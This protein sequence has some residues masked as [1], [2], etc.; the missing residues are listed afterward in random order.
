MK[1]SFKYSFL[2]L[3]ILPLF[4]CGKIESELVFPENLHTINL[5]NGNIDY[6]TPI[7]VIFYLDRGLTGYYP[8]K[9]IFKWDETFKEKNPDVQL[10]IYLGNVN[11]EEN[12]QETLDE[13]NFNYPVILDPENLFYESNKL[14][15]IPWGTTRIIGLLVRDKK[16]ID[17][18]QVGM[19]ELLQEQIAKEKQRMVR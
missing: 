12:I 2:F 3:L 14:D 11:P 9:P 13:L 16:V 1:S 6:E 18:A 17:Y 8:L 10:I 4:S 7:K 15:T 19:S 5:H